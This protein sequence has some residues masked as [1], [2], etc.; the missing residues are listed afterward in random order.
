MNYNSI[1]LIYIETQYINQYIL[2]YLEKYAYKS[3][4]LIN[5]RCFICGDS[6]TNKNKMRGYFIQQNNNWHYYCHNCQA[7]HHIEFILK[8]FFN[9]GYL[10]FIKDKMKEINESLHYANKKEDENAILNKAQSVSKTIVLNRFEKNKKKYPLGVIPDIVKCSN[11]NDEHIAKQYLIKRMIPEK[12]YSQ[13][14]YT[15]HFVNL[16]K[17]ANVSIPSDHRI[18]IPIKDNENQC[19]GYIGRLIKDNTDKEETEN[20]K[21]NASYRYLVHM[22]I[23]TN[24][25]FFNLHRI[26]KEETVKVVEGAFD[27]MFLNNSISIG[28]CNLTKYEPSLFGHK[29]HVLIFDNEPRNK[30]VMNQMRRAIFLK[31]PL[32]IWSSKFSDK[33][34]INQMI[35]SGKT[36]ETIE[37]YIANNTSN[38]LEA[39]LKFQQYVLC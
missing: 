27:S 9:S 21:T 31:R 29:D 16:C 22:K 18:I 28:S 2:P 13:L 34:D 6:N 39:K 38:G 10:S 14:Y 35:L 5:C 19:I 4:T 12:W 26:K 33:K 36:I 1:N 23:K 37:E 7:T 32:C 8:N 24:T 17:I 25:G 30:F 11:L 15:S 20:L 3:N